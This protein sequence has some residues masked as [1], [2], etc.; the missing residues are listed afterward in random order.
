MK[1]R[2]TFKAFEVRSVAALCAVGFV[3]VAL[4]AC[5]SG[6]GGV[7]VDGG[8]A[9]DGAIADAAPRS[10][11]P[12]DTRTPILVDGSDASQAPV[13]DGN[14]LPPLP[15]AGS[16][17]ASACPSL[18]LA[19]TPLRTPLPVNTGARADGRVSAWV[20]GPNL[21]VARANHCAF[22]ARDRLY[23][24][25]GNSAAGQTDRIDAILINGTGALT[26][27]E[28]K[29]TTPSP[30]AQATCTSNGTRVWLLG[31][32]FATVDH[33]ASIWTAEIDTAGNV[34]TF[35]VLGARPPDYVFYSSAA[36]I[37]DGELHALASRVGT[38]ERGHYGVHTALSGEFAGWVSNQF[39]RV[40]FTGPAVAYGDQHVYVFGGNS[41]LGLTSQAFVAPWLANGSI[42]APV[43]TTV[44]PA[45]LYK[46]STV[47]VDAYVYLIG[48]VTY[49]TGTTTEH[50]WSAM[51]NTNTGALGAWSAIRD[52]PS[53]RSHAATVAGAGKIFVTG[54]GNGGP[55]LDSFY[56]ADAQF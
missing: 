1:L 54:G 16:F 30:V 31:G 13:L 35:T 21:P 55:G 14:V 12:V 32:D 39:S 45:A 40:F 28:Q 53:P 5:A 47:V 25:G 38:C 43:A 15:D 19:S 49:P 17:D 37:R 8:G 33:R 56:Y 34:G 4:C 48:G 24:L 50:G 20:I 3:C 2:M 11:T 29:G 51:I 7:V 46:S 44:P 10:D 18:N 36:T 26:T 22:V 6:E 42:G 41:D 9:L 27:W 52:L 23:V